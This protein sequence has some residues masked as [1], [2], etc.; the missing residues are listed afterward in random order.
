[1]EAVRNILLEAQ[2]GTVLTPDLEGHRSLRGVTWDSRQVDADGLFVAIA[3]ERVDG[4]DHVVSA[5]DAGASGVLVTREPSTATLAIAEEFDCLVIQVDDAAT[6]LKA[7]AARYRATLGA[8]VVGITGSTGKT[9]TKDLIA[10]VLSTSFRTVATKGNYNNELGVPYTVLSANHDTEALVVEMGMRGQGQL[11]DLCSYVRPDI[12]VITNVGVTHME[13]LG[14]QDNIALA[15]GELLAALPADGI[16]VLNGDDPYTSFLLE[17]RA[18]IDG[19]QVITYGSGVTCDVR[20]VDVTLSDNAM[21]CFTLVLPDGSTHTVKLHLPGA[22]NVMNAL[23]A[24]AVGFAMGVPS[25]RVVEGLLLAR[26]GAMRLETVS[27]ENGAI[28]IN[29]AY[30][31]NP[32]SMRAALS[33]LEKMEVVGRRIAVLGDMGELGDNESGFHREVGVFAARSGI[34]L[35]ICVGDLSRELAQAAMD[36]GMPAERVVHL[37]NVA[38]VLE[39][40]APQLGR[41]DVVL[42]K[43]SRSMGL[44][45]VVKGLV[46]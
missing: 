41:G 13:L 24:A 18:P 27:A 22:H 28:I 4:N 38:E 8:R 9:T 43:A 5:I 34:E 39:Y 45:R 30:N 19:V 15:K 32:D 1:M 3:G 7:L 23:A 42:V 37:R 12:A 36:A 29:D 44:E 2:V 40:L 33:T 6:A 31:A 20:A 16:A 26:P 25:A 10:S 46:G 14:S 21:P 11:T 35:L 17:H